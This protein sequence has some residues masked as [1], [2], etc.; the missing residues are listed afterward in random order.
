MKGKDN[1]IMMKLLSP[2]EMEIAEI[3]TFPFINNQEQNKKNKKSSKNI[4]NTNVIQEKISYPTNIFSSLTFHWVFDTITKSK[5]NKNLKFSYL[6]SVSS[7][8]ES[9]KIFKEIEKYGMKS[10]IIY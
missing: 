10:I 5:K 9:E 6:G 3:E 4:D 2:N 8:Y 7:D 1:N